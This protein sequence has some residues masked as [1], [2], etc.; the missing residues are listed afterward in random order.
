MKNKELHANVLKAGKFGE[1]GRTA[2]VAAVAAE[3]HVK[4]PW[5]SQSILSY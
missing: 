4:N 1:H 5:S 3:N 2:A